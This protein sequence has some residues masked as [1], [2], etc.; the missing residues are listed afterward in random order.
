LEI[1]NRQG[2]SLFPVST[3]VRG[4]S[5]CIHL[6]T[7]GPVRKDRAVRESRRHCRSVSIPAD[8]GSCG[9][10]GVLDLGECAAGAA[11][12]ARGFLLPGDEGADP[13]RFATT[14]SIDAS[15]VGNLG[16]HP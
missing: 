4:L 6:H 9:L 7:T 1:C 2:N 3:L 10:T 13:Q 11:V 8:S 14:E 15:T 12:C 5:S 16:I